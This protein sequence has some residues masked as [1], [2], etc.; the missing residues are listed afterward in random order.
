[1]HVTQKSAENEI[2]YST[3]GSWIVCKSPDYGFLFQGGRWAVVAAYRGTLNFVSP[4]ALSLRSGCDGKTNL[5]LSLRSGCDVE[6]PVALSLRSGCD[7]A[8]FLGLSQGREVLLYTPPPPVSPAPAAFIHIIILL[9]GP[10][11]V[12]LPQTN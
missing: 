5:A 6:T 1:M 8:S 2:V 11:P 3:V 7:V 10:G 12:P 4:P 9:D